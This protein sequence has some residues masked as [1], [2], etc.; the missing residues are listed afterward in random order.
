[1]KFLLGLLALVVT[2][3]SYVSG[4]SAA[5]PIFF[6]GAT[7]NGPAYV[8][9][10][11]EPEPVLAVSGNG[12]FVM[13]AVPGGV[14]YTTP[15]PEAKFGLVRYTNAGPVELPLWY[16]GVTAPTA[17]VVSKGG[18]FS[19]GFDQ[20]SFI[21]AHKAAVTDAKTL[22]ALKEKLSKSEKDEDKAALKS[23][24]DELK[25]LNEKEAKPAKKAD[26]KKEEAKPEGEAEAEKTA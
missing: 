1:M 13:M 16:N 25:K 15:E 17:A 9:L 21:A 26:G 14:V 4:V 5:E 12:K 6:A 18:L 20:K 7:V 19:W 24:L 8:G 10:T 22:K 11:Q 3:V 2:C 23:I